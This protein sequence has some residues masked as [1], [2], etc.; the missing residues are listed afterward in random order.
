MYSRKFGKS[1]ALVPEIGLGCW[2]LGGGWGKAW[3]DEVAQQILENAYQAGVRFI[4]TADAAGLRGQV[5]SSRSILREEPTTP[6]TP[7]TSR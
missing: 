1:G 2:Q 4:D 5:R 7:R 6:T 3:D